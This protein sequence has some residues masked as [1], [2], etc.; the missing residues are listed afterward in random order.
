MGLDF[1]YLLYFKREDL[2]SVLQGV[3]AIAE[4]HQ[5]PIKIQFPGHEL[6]I[7]LD[8]WTLKDKQVHHDDPDFGFDT[9]LRFELDDEIEDYLGDRDYSDTNRSPPE[10]DADNKVAIGY[11]YLGINNDLSREY[12]DND[13]DNLVLFD[14]GT[15]GTRMSLLFSYS[16]SI[17]KTFLELLRKHDGVCGVFNR[18]AG[19]EVFWFKGREMAFDIDDPF[20][21]PDE[22]ESL[23]E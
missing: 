12:P 5:P 7:P 11:I 9:V 4:Q 16:T 6:S 21:L 19:G 3:V 1:S 15:P 2:W 23:S 18:E 8:S 22:I 10:P 14:F 13:V 17:R 20:M